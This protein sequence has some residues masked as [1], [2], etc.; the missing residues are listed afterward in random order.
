MIPPSLRQISRK[1]LSGNPTGGPLPV[2]RW[3]WLPALLSSLPVSFPIPAWVLAWVSAWSCLRDLDCDRHAYAP[4]PAGGIIAIVTYRR[5]APLLAA[6]LSHHRRLGITSFVF[7]D[8]SPEGSLAVR[9]QDEVDCTVWR[10]RR[11]VRGERALAWG[12]ALRNRHA[13]ARWCLSLDACDFFVFARCETRPLA[14]LTDFL[15]SEHRDHLY[16]LVIDM[17][18]DGPAAE[19]TL[20]S[21]ADPL[22][23][24]P[25]FDPSGYLTQ[26]AG[27]DRSVAVSGGVR[28]RRLFR[29]MPAEA[30]RLDRIPLVRWQRGYAYVDDTRRLRPSRLNEPH[31]P[32]HSSPTGCLLRFRLIAS[33]DRRTGDDGA[34]TRDDDAVLSSETLRTEVSRRFNGSDDLVDCGLLNP[35]QW[36]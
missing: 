35:G 23:L 16:A 32:W 1:E 30:P 33:Q 10:P 2:K 8:L 22:Q 20:S 18:G 31:A 11:A 24:M 34:L 12:N 3:R 28:R 19:M 17:Y 5:E 14:G 29:T 36:F 9:L 7:L 25:L 21:A 27:P 13:R 4:A 26:A 15:Q 6:F